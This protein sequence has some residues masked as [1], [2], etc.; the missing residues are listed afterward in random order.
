MAE[1]GNIKT[2]TINITRKDKLSSKIENLVV[3]EGTLSPTFGK[4]QL[5]YTISIPNEY[6]KITPI[7]TL[8]DENAT[9][10]IK[11]NSNFNVGN[12]VVTIEVTS[13]DKKETTI[14]TLNVIRNISSNNYLSTLKVSEGELSPEF[15]KTVGYY[16]VE[17]ENEIERITVTGT[18]V[19]TTTFIAG[20]GTYDLEVGENMILIRTMSENGIP[21]S[22]QIKVIRKAND[23]NY[24]SDLRVLEGSLNPVF[25][26][27]H[28][29]YE[30]V[31][32]EGTKEVHVEGELESE[33]ATV[34]G[35]GTHTI[36][37]GNNIIDVVVTSESG[38]LKTYRLTIVRPLS[39]NTN[40]ISFIPDT[41]ELS[42]GFT[43]DNDNYVLNI[44]KDINVVNIEVVPESTDAKVGG[45]KNITISGNSKE[46]VI[47]IL[48]EDGTLREIKVTI[49]KESS[50][51]DITI[52]NKDIL[53]VKGEEVELDITPTP[54]GAT[55][56]YVLT[57]EE[58]IITVT[59]KKIKGVL[60][61]R[62]KVTVKVEENALINKEVQVT[63][64]SN[65][66]ESNVYEV[67]DKADR[68]V[69]GA[70]EGTTIGEFKDNLLNDK[71]VI[72]I[73]DEEGELVSDTDIVRTGLI[74]KLENNE[75]VYDEAILIVRGDI[76]KDG[77]VDVTD[78]SI[79]TDH[80][81]EIEPITGAGLYA[82]DIEEDDIL[83]VSDDSTLTDYILKIID[84]LN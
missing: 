33:S 69:V 78:E 68:I 48:A 39:N 55:P 17:V 29:I 65:K 16:E 7:I 49:N 21:R 6:R 43:N 72:N 37:A 3:R 32:E 41:G 58:A 31:V 64:V 47:S 30:V 52:N 36:K 67:K 83:D 19:A 27:E 57:P 53:L 81:L 44:G 18:P 34:T 38:V 26:S 76:D 15:D 35:L 10:E 82:A 74:I 73:Y 61:G 24:L 22:Y 25:E 1:N 40:V 28:G 77:I 8:E 5:E 46:G 42:P 62:G 9:Y 66:I 60:V 71:R 56:T 63:V 54:L 70:E 20:L 45:N 2:Y 79:L 11:G 51:E 80:I 75:V 4:E 23:S 50:I 13:S 84:S 59:G 14:Y 12:N